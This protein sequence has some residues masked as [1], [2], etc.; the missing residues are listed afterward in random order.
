[1]K[2]KKGKERGGPALSGAL[3]SEDAADSKPLN[4]PGLTSSDLSSSINLDA[5][6]S[7]VAGPPTDQDGAELALGLEDIKSD[8]A[9]E[10]PLKS[11]SG[12]SDGLYCPECYLPLHPDP[13]PEKL[14]IF[15]HA[16]RYTS[17]SLGAFET[18]MPEWA[19]PSYTWEKE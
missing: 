9:S 11:E 2:K 19:A 12:S 8:T 18:A 16:L 5:L 15:L 1:M 17:E 6:A 3:N 14:Y 10:I 4:E 7:E 13:V